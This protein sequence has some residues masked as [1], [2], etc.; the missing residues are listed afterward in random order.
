MSEMNELSAELY[1][2]SNDLQMDVMPSESHLPHIKVGGGSPGYPRTSA[3][4]VPFAGGEG[5]R[6][7][8]RPSQWPQKGAPALWERQA[9]SRA[10]NSE[11]EQKKL[12]EEFDDWEDDYDSPE[13]EPA[14]RWGLQSIS[15]PWRSHQDV[16]ENLQNRN[17]LWMTRFRC[18]LKRPCWIS[19]LLSESFHLWLSVVWLKNSAVMRSLIVVECS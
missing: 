10:L 7:R 11:R 12:G 3:R 17:R 6:R 14:Q 16:S 1:E 8:R 18:I 9:R 5:P 19:W 2:E 15:G 4:P 13:E